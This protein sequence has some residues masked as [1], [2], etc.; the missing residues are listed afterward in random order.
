[1]AE[2]VRA[3]EGSGTPRRAGGSGPESLGHADLLV[4][5]GGVIGLG[6][7][8]RAAGL[9]LD[10]AV[11]DAGV[12]ERASNVAAGMIAPVGEA[13]W[14]QEELLAAALASAARWPGF[15]RE[16]GDAAGVEVPLRIRGALHVA[17]DRDERAVL[18]REHDLHE[19]LGLGAEWLRGSECRRLEPGISVAAVGGYLAAGEGEV[20]PRAVVAA[21]ERA[22]ERSGVRRISGRV[23]ELLIGDGAVGGA[24]LDDGRRIGAGRVLVAAG[25]RAAELVPAPDTPPVRPVKGEILR[26]R[27]PAG[28]RLCE[29]IV[30]AERVYV[31]P[32]AGEEVV[33][34]AT[35]ED[36]GFDSR[37][38]A[39]A[40][41]ELLREA[42]RVL[43]GIAE[44]ELV[45]A[46]AGLRPGTPDG[47]PVIGGTSV[48]GL[49]LAC[50][51]HRHG[52]LL[53]PV[54]VDA[55]EAVLRGDAVPDAVAGFGVERFA[56]AEVTA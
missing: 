1:M 20:D 30:G 43:P 34:G 35:M 4:V 46:S 42:Y 47:A 22:A 38:T 8:W 12:E 24:V 40:V 17:L 26:L 5:G 31:V 48:D 50:G 32:R 55:I 15:A 13:T 53:A 18:Q 28:E 45:E 2:E 33:V 56:G 10:V 3:G 44:L 6:C 41:H 19:R 16:L 54:T 51:H 14:N 11:V 39:G 36:R 49:L 21:L 29:R 25:A 52:I 27:A 7:A 37:V 9:G 23:A